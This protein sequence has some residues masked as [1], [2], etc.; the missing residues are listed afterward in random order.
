MML[1]ERP[2]SQSS[3]PDGARPRLP[4][5]SHLQLDRSSS[6]WLLRDDINCSG[7]PFPGEHDEARVKAIV[8][9]S[10]RRHADDGRLSTVTKT[11]FVAAINSYT[12]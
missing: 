11:V 8:T 7:S 6:N 2:L 12:R 3:T 5:G 1:G 4:P 9:C 10:A